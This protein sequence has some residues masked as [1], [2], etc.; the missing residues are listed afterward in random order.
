MKIAK[1]IQIAFVLYAAIST[2]AFADHGNAI[3]NATMNCITAATS[4]KAVAA[5]SSSA[6]EAKR[7]ESVPEAEIIYV[8]RGLGQA[9]YS[10]PR[11]TG[12]NRIN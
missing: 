7:V 8:N 3:A 12:A 4:I 10:Y 2:S 6:S 11:N 5:D 1:T 9:I